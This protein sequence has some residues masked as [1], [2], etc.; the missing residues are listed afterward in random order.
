MAR[1]DIDVVLLGVDGLGR[2]GLSV[3]Q[4]IKSARPQVEIIIIND[5]GQI[6]L[7]IEGMKLGAFDDFLIPVDIVSLVTR[8]KEAGQ[9]NIAKKY[10]VSHGNHMKTKGEAK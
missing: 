4:P 3:I 9:K 2:Q 5:S 1:E 10:T 8:I 7:S 6:D